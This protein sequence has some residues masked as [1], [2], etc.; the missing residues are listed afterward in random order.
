MAKL[1]GRGIAAVNYPTGMN[2]GGDPSQAVIYA[3]PDGRFVVLVA[4]IELGQG[5]RTALAQ[6]AAEAIGARAEDVDVRFG[7]TDAAPHDTGT[8]ASR[9]THRMG[10]A[11]AMAGEEVRE[12]L[13]DVASK[14]L[15]TRPED[16]EISNGEVRVKGVPERKV[17]VKDVVSQANFVY[18]K[19]VA[20]RG[21]YVKPKSP[22]DYETGA[23]DP[24]SAYAHACTVA[25]VEVDT[26]TGKIDVLKIYMAYD[27]GRAVNPRL[28]EGQIIGG[29]IMGMGAALTESVYPYYPGLEHQAVSFRDYVLPTAGDI[30]EIEYRVLEFPTATSRYG[31]KG[32][33]E[34]VTT[35][36]PPAIAN[37]V[38]DAIGVQITEIPITPEK[39]LEALEKKRGGA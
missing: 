19:T 24:E 26:E 7:D 23:C 13:L 3:Q 28:V 6:I 31:I 16:L 11:V 2:L 36:I 9:S 21:Y 25:E 37:A 33:G 27:V 17:L 30:P 5:I 15:E 29:A 14:I 20:G 38:Y 10:N 22:V 4:S 12:V 35:S 39:V 18:G 34:M 1:R 8:F 32:I